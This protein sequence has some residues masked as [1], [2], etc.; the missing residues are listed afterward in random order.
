MPEKK[1]AKKVMNVLERMGMVRKVETPE[2]LEPISGVDALS[3]APAIPEEFWED[4]NTEEIGG[5]SVEETIYQP[6]APVMP[7]APAQPVAVI[8][9]AIQQE[10]ER[11][12]AVTS[13]VDR[14]ME[15][16][17]LYGAFSM[18]TA[19]T[20]TIYLIEEYMKS[21]PDSLPAESRRAIIM[22]L[23]GASGF[24][25]DGLLGDGIDRVNKLNEYA[26]QFA[27]RTNDYIAQRNAELDALD[28]QMQQI[29][30]LVDKRHTLHKQQFFV[31]ETE[32]QRL[33][34]I[35]DFVTK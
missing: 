9:P 8:P 31:I 6:I 32:A 27:Q 35:L 33:K 7:A 10:I 16:S 30:A 18:K 2:E 15:V 22:K 17:S 29:R 3:A 19:G 14:F 11:E 34:E 4:P 25:F 21:L 12:L 1:D 23:I 20:D 5:A 24:N 26:A 13:Y 28:A